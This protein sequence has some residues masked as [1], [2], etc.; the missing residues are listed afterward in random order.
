M[1]WHAIDG[2]TDSVLTELLHNRTAVTLSRVDMPALNT[3]QFNCVKSR[4]P[5]HAQ[6]VP[7]IYE[8][9]VGAR[10]IAD[11]AERPKRR[12]WVGAP[13]VATVLG[14]RFAPAAMYW[15]LARTGFSGQQDPTITEPMLPP[16]LYQP[17]PG[18]HG[19]HGLFGDRA[20]SSSPQA[21]ASRHRGL[22]AATALA[23][24]TLVLALGARRS[25][26]R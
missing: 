18:D 7:P 14:N 25:A 12:T 8:P 21:W 9:E 26:T 16:N 24:I 4:L 2:F 1:R 6:P 20:H 11:V 15:Y 22:V 19:A 10:A 17:V 3:I 23:G 5:H 13:T